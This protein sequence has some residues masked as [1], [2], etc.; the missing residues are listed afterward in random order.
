MFLFVFA[1]KSN[2]VQHMWNPPYATQT[3]L[4]TYNTIWM[5]LGWSLNHQVSKVSLTLI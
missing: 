4:Y 1:F 5:I 3:E 2:F